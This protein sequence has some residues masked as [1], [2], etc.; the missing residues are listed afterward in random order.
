MGAAERSSAAGYWP[1]AARH[2][3]A[4]GAHL[5]TDDRKPR[6]GASA[7]CPMPWGRPRGELVSVSERE[8]EGFE[9]AQ[10]PVQPQ[11]SLD[12]FIDLRAEPDGLALAPPEAA[13]AAPEAA[14]SAGVDR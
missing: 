4:G 6:R 9:L 3:R 8:V 13:D 5:L 2:H 7:R 10:L 11:P 14:G 12:A 1:T